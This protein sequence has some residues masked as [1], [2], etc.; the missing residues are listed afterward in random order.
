MNSWISKNSLRL[1]RK[2]VNAVEINTQASPEWV[3][4]ILTM[5]KQ[6][7]FLLTFGSDCHEIGYD[8]GDG[9]H[10]SIWELNRYVDDTIVTRNFWE[11]RERVWS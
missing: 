5:Q 2:W 3:D 10:A 6:F 1:S 4:V 9:K 7:W 11:F 8:G